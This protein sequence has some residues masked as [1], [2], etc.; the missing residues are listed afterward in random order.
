MKK[1]ALYLKYHTIDD[2]VSQK[3]N[4]GANMQNVTLYDVSGMEHC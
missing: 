1:V 4:I 3:Q 2:E